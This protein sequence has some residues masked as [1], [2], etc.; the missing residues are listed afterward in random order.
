[1][2]C[3]A[4]RRKSAFL[5]LGLL[6]FLVGGINVAQ[7]Y[8]NE[9]Y[10]GHGIY[11]WKIND[12]EIYATGADAAKMDFAIRT[13]STG[14]RTIISQTVLPLDT[15]AHVAVTLNG[16]TGRMCLN[17]NLVGTNAAMPIES[18]HL[19]VAAQSYIGKSQFDPYFNGFH[20]DPRQR[21]SGPELAARRRSDFL[22]RHTRRR[23]DLRHIAAGLAAST[24]DDTSV[25]SG[26]ACYYVVTG[27][28]TAVKA[29][30]RRRSLATPS[31]LRV[32]LKFDD[33]S[34]TLAADSSGRGRDA[35]T[36]NNPGWS[37][38]RLNNAFR[39]SRRSEPE[40]GRGAVALHAKS[41]QI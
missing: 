11:R 9:V 3:D 28:S 25:N 1:M 20:R 19:G 23:R 38:G 36:V 13:P 37:A 22:Q 30:P 6:A 16:A 21:E 5:L 40:L 4:A 29:R 32:H 2:A 31:T 12:T 33:T 17:G 24:Y 39:V 34:G 27:G 18:S 14:A 35:T 41:L 10:V 26:T 8:S 15:W 7:A